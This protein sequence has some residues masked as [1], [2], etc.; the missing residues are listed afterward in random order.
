MDWDNVE[1]DIDPPEPKEPW[2]PDPDRQRDEW[3]EQEE[4]NR[5]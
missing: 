3:L 2:E 4:E 5:L 1:R